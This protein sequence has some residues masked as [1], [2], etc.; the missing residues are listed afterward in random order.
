MNSDQGS[1]KNGKTKNWGRYSNLMLVGDQGQV[2]PFRRF[3]SLAVTVI[4]ALIVSLVL[5]VVLGVILAGRSMK[6]NT[7]QVA[8]KEAQQQLSQM[9]DEK[10][11]L[12]TQIVVDKSKN[13]P[14]SSEIKS[15]AASD[16]ITSKSDALPPNET[17][18]AKAAPPKAPPPALEKVP[19]AQSVKL[20]A[21]AQRIKV[22]YQPDRQLL[23][24]SFRINNTSKP[25]VPLSGRTVVVFKNQDDPP[26]QW[27][28]VP[29]VQLIGGKPSGKR[30]KAFKINN[31]RTESFK[32]FRLKLPIRFNTAT[33][34]IFSSS[35]ELLLS[36]DYPFKIEAKPT[37][38]PIIPAPKPEGAK[39]TQPV[40][41]VTPVQK[42]VPSPLVPAPVDGASGSAVES[43]GRATESP[44]PSVP[45]EQTPTPEPP[46]GVTPP[47]AGSQNS[48]E[49][50][51]DP[52]RSATESEPTSPPTE[53]VPIQ[54]QPI[55]QGE[56]R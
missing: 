51:V 37:P 17:P 30:G 54:S 45:S 1:R 3:K 4:G 43:E 8:L 47:D 24:L 31:Y 35:G 16:T 11:L 10:D 55:T 13:D 48:Q 25:K 21:D 5:V 36:K 39:R 46:S 53:M 28:A 15:Q 19:P 22:S 26:I 29:R 49:V 14:T 41:P 44:A 42:S 9:R 52:E 18:V 40:V 33:I 34:Y 27:L 2:I 7:L 12:L 6:I 38:K 32:A 50:T 23:S 20:G 56:Q